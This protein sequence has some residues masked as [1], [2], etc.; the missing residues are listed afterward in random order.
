MASNGLFLPPIASHCLSLPVCTLGPLA[1]RPGA[2]VPAHDAIARQT[3]ALAPCKAR[4]ATDTGHRA[5][6]SR[7]RVRAA[8]AENTGELATNP[9]RMSDP[10][11]PGEGRT[12]YARAVE[13]MYVRN[14]SKRNRSWTKP[15]KVKR[16][17]SPRQVL[18]TNMVLV[19]T[20]SL[21]RW[22]T[23]QPTLTTA[24]TRIDSYQ[25]C[26]RPACV[27]CSQHVSGNLDLALASASSALAYGSPPAPAPRRALPSPPQW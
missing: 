21:Q 27:L 5:P 24:H 2:R 20:V 14:S 8:A 6:R 16:Q 18:S 12:K 1:P 25:P 9:P 11:S 13:P 26:A 3:A 4:R 17:V 15:R 7:G 10:P 23:L 22:N 19:E